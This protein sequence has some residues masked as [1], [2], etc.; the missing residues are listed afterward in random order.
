MYSISPYGESQ[1]P[2]FLRNVGCSGTE[3]SLL[4]CT[5]QFVTDVTCPSHTRDVGVKCEGKM[6]Q[7]DTNLYK[8]HSPTFIVKLELKAG[9]LEALSIQKSLMI[10][11]QLST[12]PHLQAI[13][14]DCMPSQPFR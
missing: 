14:N 10:F 11:L 5:S 6:D 9:S 4:D 8:Y 3:E 12:L 2:S 13:M 1:G 7:N